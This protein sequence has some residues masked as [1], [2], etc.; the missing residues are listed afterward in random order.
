MANAGGAWDNAKKLVEVDLKEKG[1]PLHAATVVGDTVGDP[2]KD[3]TSVALNPIIKFS[4]LFGLLAVEI[5]VGMEPHREPRPR[6]RASWRSRWCSCGGRST[7]CASRP[8]RTAPSPRPPP[9]P[10]A[11]RLR[12]RSPAS[13]LLPRPPAWRPARL[14]PTPGPGPSASPSRNGAP[15][16]A[17]SR[18][19]AKSLRPPNVRERGFVPARPRGAIARARASGSSRSLRPRAKPVPASVDRAGGA[20]PGLTRGPKATARP[21]RAAACLAPRGR[22][23][24]KQRQRGLTGGR[25]DR[26]STETLPR[27]G[28]SAAAVLEGRPR[29]GAAS[30]SES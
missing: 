11:R 23:G 26:R 5:A 3:T 1:T 20:E 17:L 12:P 19:K 28:S 21:S 16:L 14:G 18:Q 24:T 10:R 2:F 29:N 6:R 27:D 15:P 13:V 22:A 9:S 25:L 30:E 8:R 7:P 4:T